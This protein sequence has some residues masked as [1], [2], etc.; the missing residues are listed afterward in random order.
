MV[1]PG[2]PEA[3]PAEERSW[4]GGSALW[5]S[6]SPPSSRLV[7]GVCGAALDFVCQV[8]APVHGRRA[9]HVFVC[10]KHA[11]CDGGWRVVRTQCGFGLEQS[12]SSSRAGAQPTKQWA[13]ASAWAVDDDDNDDDDDLEAMLRAHERAGEEDSATSHSE[14][15]AQPVAEVLQCPRFPRSELTWVAAV[16]AAEDEEEEEEHDESMLARARAYLDGDAELSASSRQVVADAVAGLSVGEV[17]DAEEQY[18]R[19][20]TAAA[21]SVAFAARLR[22]HPTQVVRYA[23]GAAPLRL[24]ATRSAGAPRCGCGAARSFEFDLLPTLIYYLHATTM[25]DWTTVSVWSCDRS[26]DHSTTE[27]A[28]VQ[29]I[30]TPSGS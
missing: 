1:R 17:G 7:C 24:T 14:R 20:P 12:M 9:L 8:Y 11:L 5:L 10:E 23:Y 13:T 3:V 25:D 30:A 21:A 2:P 15:A 18:E 16:A 19:A 28:L 22:R 6:A 4:I 26:C 29:P 27:V